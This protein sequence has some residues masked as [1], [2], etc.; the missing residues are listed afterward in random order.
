MEMDGGSAFQST[1]EIPTAEPP[2]P[3]AAGPNIWMEEEAT[4]RSSRG[5][6]LQQEDMTG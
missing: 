6:R 4:R 3:A 2:G 1:L 5:E